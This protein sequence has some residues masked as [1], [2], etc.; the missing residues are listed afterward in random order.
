LKANIGHLVCLNAL[1][2]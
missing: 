2:A 1:A